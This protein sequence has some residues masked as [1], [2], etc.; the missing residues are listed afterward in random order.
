M[1]M[2]LKIGQHAFWLS[3]KSGNIVFR[4]LEVAANYVAEAMIKTRMDGFFEKLT[5][6]ERRGTDWFVTTVTEEMWRQATI[7]LWREEN[8]AKK[9][10]DEVKMRVVKE[11]GKYRDGIENE[12]ASD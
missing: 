2:S 11:Y 3:T 8:K 5:K 1:A 7:I 9:E 10:L 6:I 12:K 4:S